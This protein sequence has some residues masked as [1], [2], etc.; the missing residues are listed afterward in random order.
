MS[1]NNL[2]FISDGSL[3]NPIIQSQGLP[4]LYS[5]AA[6]EHK[7]FLITFENKKNKAALKKSTTFLISKN[8][9]HKIIYLDNS[10]LLSPVLKY[11]VGGLIIS[12]Y[13]IFRHKVKIVHC[14]SLYPSII[15]L[16]AKKLLG[17]IYLLYD[18][19]GVFIDEEIAK[20]SVAPSSIKEK[21]LRIAEKQILL[22]FDKI[23]V[24]SIA[25]KEYLVTKNDKIA[26]KIVV[27]Y[28][29]TNI[30]RHD[31][32]TLRE[33]K[34]NLIVGVYSGSAAL[35]QNIKNISDF[36]DC[37]KKTFD[38]FKLKI[39]TYEPAKFEFLLSGRLKDSI[40]EI[41]QVLPSEI[42]M[43]LITANF[44]ILLR[45]KNLINKV[46]FPLKFSEYLAAGL[47]VLLTEG[48][49]DTAEIVN[50]FKIGS[51]LTEN[52]YNR[53]LAEMKQ[54]LQDPEIYSRCYKTAD[55]NFNL[56]SAIE[57][58]QNIYNEF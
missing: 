29:N 16:V 31:V 50:K 28:N 10:A 33:L 52:N 47:P 54:L 5:Y 3:F 51:V 8:V 22:R 38:N 6:K 15:G 19:R 18:N 26:C 25:F 55:E 23:V 12:L 43:E 46:S 2:L 37:A 27:I 44:G 57:T 32:K 40:I 17:K 41:K 4:L 20:M 48:I 36:I 24:V 35:W 45:E 49:G 11:F 9:H 39:I 56:Q 30:I 1:C 21:F 42:N 14:R 58:Y 53:A 13:I 7:V 34:G